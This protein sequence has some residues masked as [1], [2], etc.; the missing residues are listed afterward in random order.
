M[1]PPAPVSPSRPSSRRP[2]Q[3][4]P[5][6][7]LPRSFVARNQRERLLSA[8]ASV[9]MEHGYPSM[10]IEQIASEAGVS[11]KTFYVHFK[12]K[13]EAFLAAYRE[14]VDRLTATVNR[15]FM[16]D[17]D[18]VARITAALDAFLRFLAADAAFAYLCV[19][20]VHAAG[21]QA[22]ERRASALEFFAEY[23]ELG[24]KE[25]GVNVTVPPMAAQTLVG[26]IYEVVYRHVVDEQTEELPSLLPELV[27]NAVLPYVG[28]ERAA[29]EYKRLR[30]QAPG[31][32]G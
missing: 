12:S 4:P 18:W 23:F 32:Q 31:G 26:G 30:S 24:R 28:P 3:L 13:E 17:G 21:R 9:A 10:T 25:A 20:E 7:G 14:V 1:F 29:A 27:F 15:S 6:P 16:S 19:V 11:K 5:G 2:S 22:L 8:V